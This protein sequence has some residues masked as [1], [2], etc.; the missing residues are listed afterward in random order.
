MHELPVDDY[1]L[2]AIEVHPAV[3]LGAWWVEA[4]CPEPMPRYKGRPEQCRMIAEA[5]DFPVGSAV[6]D[7]ALDAFVAHRLGE[8]F[9]DG[10]ASCVGDRSAGGY[11]MP[12]CAAT[13]ELLDD[14]SAR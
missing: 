14:L 9:L 11:V 10:R 2:A 7:D 8:L 3:A 13:E 6:D 5:L 1:R 12:N 4:G